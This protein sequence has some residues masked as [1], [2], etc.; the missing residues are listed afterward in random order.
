MVITQFPLSLTSVERLA[1][2]KPK[3]FPI[4]INRSGVVVIVSSKFQEQSTSDM[5]MTIQSVLKTRVSSL[6][7]VVSCLVLVYLGIV[8]KV[9]V[10][11]LATFEDD[12]TVFCSL[13][14]FHQRS[15]K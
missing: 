11:D 5:K 15:L 7:F 3:V 1:V 13:S 10:N 4:Q 8:A 14:Q 12:R 2:K 6:L 9:L